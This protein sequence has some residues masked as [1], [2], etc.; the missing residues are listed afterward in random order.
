MTEITLSVKDE[1][2]KEYGTL[3]IKDFFEKQLENLNL[4]RQMDKIK[5][6]ILSSNMDYEKEL[7]NVRQKAWDEYKGDFLSE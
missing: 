5:K 7:E 1:V 2:I 3:F 6:H 4:L